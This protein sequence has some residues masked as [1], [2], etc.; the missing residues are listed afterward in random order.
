M[1]PSASS[2]AT[3]ERQLGLLKAALSRS[4]TQKP[5]KRKTP[6]ESAGSGNA[7]FGALLEARPA[8]FF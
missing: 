2:A 4:E 1:L 5:V 3:G 7:D 6:R 8:N